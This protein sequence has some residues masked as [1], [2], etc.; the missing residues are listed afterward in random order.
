MATEFKT[1]KAVHVAREFCCWPQR[2]CAA[3]FTQPDA[4]MMMTRMV[5]RPLRAA[6]DLVEVVLVPPTDGWNRPGFAGLARTDFGL[7]RLLGFLPWTVIA[8]LRCWCD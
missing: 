4:M 2:Q 5:S 7:K 8:G 3:T 6:N 1:R